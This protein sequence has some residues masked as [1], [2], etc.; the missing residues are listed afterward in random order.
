MRL[1]FKI[2]FWSGIALFLVVSALASWGLVELKSTILSR[3]SA[4][5]M[6]MTLRS[7]LESLQEADIVFLQAKNSSQEE[8]VKRVVALVTNA[9]L[10]AQA[11]TRMDLPN[12]EIKKEITELEVMIGSKVKTEDEYM[13][14][15]DMF[16]E[17]VVKKVT[18]MKD[19]LILTHKVHEKI[20][21]VDHLL[22]DYQIK[23]LAYVDKYFDINIATI[24]FGV[25]ASFLL[26]LL[27][28]NLVSREIRR[29]TQLEIE[30]RKAQ[31]AAIA[32]SALKSQFLATV[33]HEVRTPL[34]GIIGMS[35]L[36]QGMAQGEL[37][38]YAGVIYDSGRSL[39]R[40]VNDI[41]D[42]SRIE[43]D[44][45]ELELQEVQLSRLFE[46]ACE[47]FGPRA[48]EKRIVLAAN[49]STEFANHFATD[50]ARIAQVLHNLLGNAIKFTSSGYVLLTG[51]VLAR[52][53][54]EYKIRMTVE[55]S[56]VGIAS[57][58][59]VNIFEPFHQT[60]TEHQREGT[61]L[62]LSISKRLVELMG[63]TIQFSSRL[64]SG[65]KFYFDLPMRGLAPA[66]PERESHSFAIV[67]YKLQ[68]PVR[69]VL[70]SFAQQLGVPY[71]NAE[72]HV[73][74]VPSSAI[75]CCTSETVKELSLE[76]QK[77]ALVIDF[78]S[79]RTPQAWRFLS[80][81][82]TLERFS[83]AAALAPHTEEKGATPSPSQ[84]L[85]PRGN[86]LILVVEDNST[87]QILAQAQLEQ[88]GYRVHL[89]QNGEEALA[90]MNRTNYDLILMD[91]RMPALD[92]FAT[93]KLI[94][95]RE[96][97]RQIGRVPII[98]ITANALAED[99]SRCL[100]AGMDDYLT[101]P[102]AVNELQP[103]L[104]KWMGAEK[105]EMD[106]RVISDLANRTNN[107][108]V[109]RLIDSFQHTLSAGLERVRE[110]VAHQA[111]PEVSAEVHQLKSSAAALGAVPLAR[112][113]A[114][115]ENEIVAHKHAANRESMA[116][117]VNLCES[118]Q[119]VG[120]RVLKELSAQTKYV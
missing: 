117:C 48:I 6:Q 67:N 73:T 79:T 65:S 59:A 61:G 14:A 58:K 83:K 97:Q 91:C 119:S 88:L 7:M 89:A 87:N 74:A 85:I 103:V 99:R 17:P 46:M 112:L 120:R 23:H 45:M 1:K 10:K 78:P 44:R 16:E 18:T 66:P 41:L 15:G 116:A 95:E 19:N 114:Q 102:L 107:E 76:N 11:L 105:L 2:L 9:H 13:V 51:Q 27:F 54:N 43:A 49:Y 104:Q 113:C 52:E 60:S 82:L 53:G 47:L 62:G 37:K 93:T 69:E 77:H 36:I 108:V 55:D 42:F 8:P 98:A 29:R 3:R 63:G 111:W 92:G 101:K 40:I 106:W 34:N 68:H 118:L 56:G 90:A 33:S 35:E 4:D 28:A 100:V 75:F 5:N 115:I 21:R 64:G 22:S 20:N 32:A 109:K 80:L 57:D 71:Q 50:G 24:S 31:D 81:P 25:L 12:A 30:L 38:K 70:H 72:L 86:G 84:A 94:R 96:R 110:S 39:L 26:F